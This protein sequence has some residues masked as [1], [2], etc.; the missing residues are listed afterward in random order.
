MSKSETVL[1]LQ[2]L[3]KDMRS[4]TV[5]L[6]RSISSLKE[7]LDVEE[8][9]PT[10]LGEKIRT[11]LEK[12]N[13]KQTEFVSKYE[14]LNSREPNTKYVV[15]ENELEEAK[16]VFEEN[17]RYVNGIKFFLSL[18]SDDE[19]TENIL[20]NR[21]NTLNN[22]NIDAMERDDLQSLG[23]PYIWLQE[24]FWE[25]DAKKKFSLMYRLASCFEEE[26]AMGIQFGTLS[27]KEPND[28]VLN[29]EITNNSSEKGAV[30]LD[31]S[32]SPVDETEKDENNYVVKNESKESEMEEPELVDNV[33]GKEYEGILVKEKP[34]IL[35]V[36]MSS[37]AETKFGVKEFRNDII[38]QYPKEKLECMVEALK[39]CGYSI[40]SITEK[41]NGKAE[42]YKLSTEKLYQFGYLK[43]YVVDK[44][45]EFFTLSPRGKRAFVAKDSLSFINQ[46]IKEKVSSQDDGEPIED[47]ANSSIVRLLSF[48]SSIKQRKLVPDYEFVIRMNVM[49]TDYFVEGYPGKDS[50]ITNWFAGIVTENVEQ[51]QEFKETV[52]DKVNPGD[53]LIVTGNTLEQ[54][55]TVA[56]WLLSEFTL[57]LRNIGYTTLFENSVY[58][59]AT[60]EPILFE[61]KESIENDE[62]LTAEPPILKEKKEKQQ[63]ED[64]TVSLEE[65][66]NT[67]ENKTIGKNGVAENESSSEETRLLKEI[68]IEAEETGG[69]RSYKAT[70]KTVNSAV[71]SI[72]EEE[73]KK[74]I[75]TYQKMIVSGKTYAASAYLKALAK[76]HPYF[77]PFY[78]QLAYAVND[79]MERCTYSSDT[80][81]NVFYGDTVP[82]SDYYIV[83]AALRNYF[84]DQY[85]YDY[86]I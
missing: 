5:D 25:I 57:E 79:P 48:D 75:S 10:S 18:H 71:P 58:D 22:L 51:L 17:D 31:T 56:N 41:K 13:E 76:Q 37:K 81:F 20:Q 43:R 47:T 2:E 70:T 44:M 64:E 16:K 82:I 68:V 59:I 62:N 72:L 54:A 78:R 53:V 52:N 9:I 39:G 67:G 14:A 55:E 11:Y 85:S 28:E 83:A 49:A 32:E 7:I 6:N 74:Y 36:Q 19:K 30:E 35:H 80:I 34:F 86:S 8:F 66:E 23:K 27:I 77:E 50:D 33:A 69:N 12:I 15:L 84:F 42:S 65:S 45:G 1:E 21:K 63:S 38:K 3:L 61:T 73:K 24:A 46:N 40:K 26:I 4:I 60:K 29:V